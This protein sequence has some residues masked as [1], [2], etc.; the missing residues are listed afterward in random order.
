MGLRDWMRRLGGVPDPGAADLL[1]EIDV[2]LELRAEEFARQGMS[3]REAKQAARE[4]FGSAERIQRECSRLAH[5]DARLSRRYER[6][7][8]L[9]SDIRYALRALRQAP[10]FAF[11]A[12]LTLALGIGANAAIFSLY[13]Q[14]LLRPLPVED[15]GALVNLAAPGV[16]ERGI[17]D[18]AP[19]PPAYGPRP[20][21]TDDAAED[22]P[23]P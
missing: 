15:P 11:V 13:H 23:A 17:V 4:A 9:R 16:K 3:R 6:M 21:P 18:P 1:K 20:P 12:T 19:P 5:R 22:A 14:M 10:G 8:T 7:A 2:Y